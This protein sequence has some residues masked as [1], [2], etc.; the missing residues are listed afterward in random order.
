MCQ[1]IQVLKS[2]GY[3]KRIVELRNKESLTFINPSLFVGVIWN[4]TDW[5]HMGSTEPVVTPQWCPGNPR[6]TITRVFL[7]HN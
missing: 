4:G 7:G 3:S 1:N 2:A 6:G 5:I